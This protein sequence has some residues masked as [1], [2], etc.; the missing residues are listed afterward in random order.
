MSLQTVSQSG[1]ANRPIRLRT[2]PTPEYIIVDL[3]GRF[4]RPL[5]CLFA[6]TL[7]SSVTNPQKHQFLLFVT[8]ATMFE[9]CF[10]Q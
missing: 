3:I 1:H 9:F 2:T 6:K 7:K 4:A 8:I 5:D 10:P